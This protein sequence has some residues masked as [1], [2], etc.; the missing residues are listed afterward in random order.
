M[1]EAKEIC[2]DANIAAVLSEP[3]GIFMLKESQK[4]Y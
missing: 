4:R 2:M 3:G 1:A